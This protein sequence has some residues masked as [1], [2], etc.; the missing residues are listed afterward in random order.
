VNRN[1]WVKNLVVLLIH[2][3]CPPSPRPSPPGE[4]AR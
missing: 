2:E 1:G 4:G 3:D